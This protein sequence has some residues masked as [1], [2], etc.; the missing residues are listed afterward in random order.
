M[1]FIQHNSTIIKLLLLLLVCLAACLP[2]D[3]STLWI[4][5]RIQKSG[6]TCITEALERALQP[7]GASLY[8]SFELQRL[9]DGEFEDTD[10]QAEAVARYTPWTSLLHGHF[11]Y[12]IHKELP[13]KGRST[14]SIISMVEPMQRMM[15]HYNFRKRIGLLQ[16]Q[17]GVESRDQVSWSLFLSEPAVLMCNEMTAVL[18]GTSRLRMSCGNYTSADYAL[19][20]RAK[21]HVARY[22]LILLREHMDESWEMLHQ[23]L[24]R[25]PPQPSCLW[26]N[27]SKQPKELPNWNQQMKLRHATLLDRL[28]YRYAHDLFLQQ[29]QQLSVFIQ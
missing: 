18:S 23:L 22:R 26:D 24:P 11:Y 6:S 19:L 1:T 25:F 2:Q 14:L 3:C 28:L 16:R 4:Y 10:V 29:A 15:S 5:H 7:C 21:Q 12:G 13:T 27:A 20:Q 8:V 9:P 17:L